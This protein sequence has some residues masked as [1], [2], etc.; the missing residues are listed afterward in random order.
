MYMEYFV[1]YLIRTTLVINLQVKMTVQDFILWLGQ[2]IVFICLR[3]FCPCH[4]KYVCV[5]LVV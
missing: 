2:N 4:K 1:R 3:L 5:M